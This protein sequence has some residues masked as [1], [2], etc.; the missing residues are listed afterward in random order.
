MKIAVVFG[1]PRKKGRGYDYLSTLQKFFPDREAIELDWIYLSDYE[2]N[3]C[4][5]CMVCYEK[6]EMACPL[7]DDYLKVIERL[8][9][10]DAVIFYSPTYAL[11]VTGTIK[12]FFDRSSFI[13]HRPLFKG[14]YALVLTSVEVFGEKYA[15][16]TLCRIVSGMG[17]RISNSMRII[18][19][20]YRGKKTYR[21]AIG[22]KL[23]KAA[24]SFISQTAC[25]KIIQ[26]TLIELIS[27]NY[28]KRI[29]S[30]GQGAEYDR[31]YWKKAGWTHPT[32]QYFYS[33]KIPKLKLCLAY[34]GTA[35]LMKTNLIPHIKA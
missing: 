35:I 24:E 27:Y 5:G 18:N 1:S 2:I 7:K 17:F 12:N 8:Y 33:V 34:I 15:S 28:Q 29:F 6:G 21:N 13:L 25:K 30:Q 16:Q 32:S 9:E 14:K 11:S 4:K 20:K 3:L 26:P 10:A 31:D 19:I 22:R 23:Q